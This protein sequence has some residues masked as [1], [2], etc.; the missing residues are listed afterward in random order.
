MVALVKLEDLEEQLG[1]AIFDDTGVSV[2]VLV[3]Y[4]FRRLSK[5]HEN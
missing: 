3:F 5:N 1:V 4:C 2:S